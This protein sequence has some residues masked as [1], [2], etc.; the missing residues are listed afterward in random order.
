MS[1]IVV[2]SGAPPTLEDA[3]ME[4]V[5]RDG[6]GSGSGVRASMGAGEEGTVPA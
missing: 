5:S 1:S 6:A 2:G 4:I 3:N